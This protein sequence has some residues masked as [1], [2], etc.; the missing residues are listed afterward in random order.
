MNVLQTYHTFCSSGVLLQVRIDHRTATL[1]FEGAQLRSDAMAGH[2][3]AIAAK[4]SAAAPAINGDAIAKAQAARR[5]EAAARARDTAAALNEELLARKVL[6]ERRKEQAEQ[7]REQAEREEEDKRKA[8]QVKHMFT[9][10]FVLTAMS[11][12]LRCCEHVQMRMDQVEHRTQVEQR[13]RTS[14]TLSRYP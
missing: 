11:C 6:I 3:S 7:D 5:A 12:G 10:S 1:H 4:L 9:L 8:E 2:L 14:A 13:H